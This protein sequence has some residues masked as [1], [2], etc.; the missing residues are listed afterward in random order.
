MKTTKIE[1]NE[2]EAKL[3]IEFRKRF[4]FIGYLV[5][6]METF[7]MFD[8]KSANIEIDIDKDGIIQHTA[9]TKHYRR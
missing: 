9:I 6:Y 1:L 3:F 5:G 4:D 2:D 7:G 8:L